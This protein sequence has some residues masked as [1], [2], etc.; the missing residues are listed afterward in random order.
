MASTRTLEQNDDF[1]LKFGRRRVQS[2]DLVDVLR[3][4]DYMKDLLQ[5][6]SQLGPLKIIKLPAGTPVRILSP[7]QMTPKSLEGL[8]FY[9][10]F[11]QRRSVQNQLASVELQS[12]F[13]F[14]DVNEN[15][16][17]IQDM[18]RQA[19][20]IMQSQLLKSGH[21][22]TASLSIPDNNDKGISIDDS[23]RS[24]RSS[25]AKQQILLRGN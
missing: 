12:A 22:Q 10:S 2:F 20:Q 24:G 25:R 7:K 6:E 4:S 19:E 14:H 9:Q 5:D 21:K 17:E 13:E 16:D 8:R 23:P 11:K 15:F 1:F 3:K 18:S